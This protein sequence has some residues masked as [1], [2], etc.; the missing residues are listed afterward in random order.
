MTTGIRFGVVEPHQF[1]ALLVADADG[2]VAALGFE[3]SGVLWKH[4]LAQSYIDSQGRVQDSLR[5]ALQNETL[6]FVKCIGDEGLRLLVSK[7]DSPL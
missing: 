6:S 3:A 1:A 4:L 2:Q 5:A 7:E